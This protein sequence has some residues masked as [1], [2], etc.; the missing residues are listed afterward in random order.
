MGFASDQIYSLKILSL[1]WKKYERLV[2]DKVSTVLFIDPQ[3]KELGLIN[4][5]FCIIKQLSF[6]YKYMILGLFSQ[7]SVLY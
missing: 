2:F 4:F 3:V 6:F 7:I 5:N 1:S